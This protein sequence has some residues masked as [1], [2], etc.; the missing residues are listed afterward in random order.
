[1]IMKE[2][3]A[4]LNFDPHT[5]TGIE[6]IT[7]WLAMLF[8][9]LFLNFFVVPI[10]I[11]QQ[12]ENYALYLFVLFVPSATKLI[13]FSGDPILY[14]SNAEAKFFQKQLPDK[15]IAAKWSVPINK[16]RDLW[17]KA[18]RRKESAEI[19]ITYEYGFTCRLI[20]YIWRLAALSA[21]IAG[22]FLFVQTAISYE[23]IYHHWHSYDLKSLVA[24]IKGIPN[25]KGKLFY[26]VHVSALAIYLKLANRPNSKSPTGVWAKWRDI[27]DQHRGWID[28]F[29]S[30]EAFKR[31][32]TQP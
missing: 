15:H 2:L 19:S 21:F 7:V 4:H 31:F 22:L 25:W 29:D 17:F 1:M 32:A 30:F 12:P 18:Y 26:F 9:F 24:S 16:A 14:R 27:N 13:F 20:Y 3:L 11:P 6:N 10:A 5:K 23:N 8:Y 28:E